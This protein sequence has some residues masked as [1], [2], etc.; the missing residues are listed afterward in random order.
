MSNIL[1]TDYVPPERPYSLNELTDNR[2]Q[3]F[4]KF[5]I[6]DTIAEHDDCKHFYFTKK[7]GK[8]EKSIKNNE[9]NF[10]DC[11]V[12]W[13]IKKTPKNLQEKCNFLVNEYMCEFYENPSIYCYEKL[14]LE[15]TFYTWLYH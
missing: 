15:K 11:S 3:F 9:T 10:G 12:C 5:R 6:G 13:K 14:D 2:L 7:N 4:N 8:K 1:E